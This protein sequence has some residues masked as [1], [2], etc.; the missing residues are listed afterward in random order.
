M[1]FKTLQF[2]ERDK[3]QNGLYNLFATT[4]VMNRNVQVF[5]YPVQKGEDMRIDLIINSIYKNDKH[6]N[7]ILDINN[8]VNPVTI[9]AGDLLL[10]VNEEDIVKYRP[11]PAD[12]PKRMPVARRHRS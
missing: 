2:L 6:A 3:D 7:F 8:I 1:D 10:Y 5:G 9:K 11:N 4:F 12:A